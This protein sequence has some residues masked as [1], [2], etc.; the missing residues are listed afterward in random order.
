MNLVDSSGW[1]EYFADGRNARF[2]E[3]VLLN[4][5]TLLVSTINLYEV[6][7][8][9]LR[10]R[11]E[12]AALQAVSAM[13]KGLVA[14]VDAE[15]ALFAS[16]ISIEHHLPMADSIIYATAL[17]YQAV[18][19]TQDEDFAKLPGVRFVSKKSADLRP[20]RSIKK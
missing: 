10:Q 7:K 19:W 3:P 1:L 12:N 4:D 18:L 5:S 8:T 13:K 9:I 14:D 20:P 6:F 11:D 16:K 2:F 15:L 17:K